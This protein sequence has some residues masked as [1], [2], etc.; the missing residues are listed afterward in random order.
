MKEDNRN[1][2]ILENDLLKACLN[3]NEQALGSI[4]Q[5]SLKGGLLAQI[6]AIF[7][8]YRAVRRIIKDNNIYL[9]NQYK[10]I[11]T[12][13]IDNFTEDKALEALEKIAAYEN[14]KLAPKSYRDYGIK[15]L[16]IGSICDTCGDVMK[17]FHGD[18]QYRIMSVIKKE[19][20]HLIKPIK[21]ESAKYSTAHF[22]N[23][24]ETGRY[25]ELRN[26]F[27]KMSE[28]VYKFEARGLKEQA[29]LIRTDANTLDVYFNERL[30][31]VSAPSVSPIEDTSADNTIEV[32]DA[33]RADKIKVD[34]SVKAELKE[35]ERQPNQDK[36]ISNDADETSKPIYSNEVAAGLKAQGWTIKEI[37]AHFGVAESTVRGRLKKYE[38][39]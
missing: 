3:K 11:N 21:L 10:I 24:V 34:E 8:T 19:F 28:D 4:L 29:E 22:K 25:S 5:Y 16:G 13:K 38:S 6:W 35:E 20:P 2:P 26:L 15:L 33:K 17:R 31:G 27:I 1:N 7:A 36:T 37:G 23:L 12:M 18:F 30:N 32:S 39:K 9:V 14:N